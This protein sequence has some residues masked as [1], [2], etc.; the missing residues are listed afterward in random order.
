MRT[1]GNCT[2]ERDQFDTIAAE[3]R[4]GDNGLN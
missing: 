4:H 2:N 3:F 1:S